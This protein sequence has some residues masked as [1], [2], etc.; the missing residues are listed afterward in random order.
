MAAAV[1][2]D[3]PP[4]EKLKE[5]QTNVEG[6]GD[7]SSNSKSSDT[8][9]VDMQEIP[10]A[11][12]T[13]MQVPKPKGA[14]KQK[15]KEVKEDHADARAELDGILK[16]SPSTLLT[17]PPL[18]AL[19]QWLTLQVIIFSKSYCP[20][21]ARA[22]QILLNKYNIVPAPYVVELDQH[23]LG[24]DL[25]AV[26]AQ[27][28]GRRTVPNVMVLG[29]SIGGGDDMAALDQSGEME[30]KLKSVGGTRIMEVTR[31]E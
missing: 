2:G 11:G 14:E 18:R 26:L 31:N 24:P 10:V 9:G 16:R 20:H 6:S 4:E 3:H 25:Q 27:L 22:K 29:K 7:S 15:E 28:T 23:P 1:A 19:I 30:S 12:R 8:E 17:V 5:K 21:S 13:K